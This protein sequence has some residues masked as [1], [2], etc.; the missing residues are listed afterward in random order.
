M[1]RFSRL[2]HEQIET[3]ESLSRAIEALDRGNGVLKLT[4]SFL[5][6]VS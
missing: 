2:E 4:T 6:S 1:Y 5:E 3:L